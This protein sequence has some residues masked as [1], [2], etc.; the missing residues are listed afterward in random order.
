MKVARYWVTAVVVFAA[1]L[2]AWVPAEAA[3]IPPAPILYS[4]D[5]TLAGGAPP[6]SVTEHPTREVTASWGGTTTVVD[7]HINMCVENCITAVVGDFVSVPGI[8]TNGRYTL[9]LG[10]PDSSYT[11]S[12]IVFYYEGVVMAQETD[13]YR[14]AL[15]SASSA[16][17]VLRP[18]FTLT[19]PALPTPTPIPTSTPVPTATPTVTPVPTATP[20]I[21]PV[22]VV[23]GT[24]NVVSGD[25][26]VLV[27]G[28]VSGR[29]SS[30]FSESVPVTVVREGLAVFEGLVLEPGDWKFVGKQVRFDFNG[31]SVR[32]GQEFLFPSEGGV[33]EVELFME[34][35]ALAAP[36]VVVAP[37]PTSD[38]EL[39]SPTPEPSPLPQPISVLGPTQT[40]VPPVAVPNVQQ[41]DLQKSLAA[42][43]AALEAKSKPVG[44]DSTIPTQTPVV[45]VVTST[46]EP[47]QEVPVQEPEGGCN[48]VG[49]VSP[50]NGAGNALMMFGPLLLLGGYRG[51]RK[52]R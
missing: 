17:A 37:A 50:L 12:D 32:I 31:T 38:P 7:D 26:S 2:A 15:N 23:G 4:G 1:G 13:N 42:A 11:N 9:T 5:V 29:V 46:P 40:P 49:P 25:P 18:N 21:P 8:I 48:S 3:G 28:N 47:V 22:M 6:D 44:A 41:A 39:P 14:L 16:A 10:V 35:P 36:S 45:I 52:R 33:F 20:P 51:W 24:V 43:I 34:G 30:Y 19:F 27:G